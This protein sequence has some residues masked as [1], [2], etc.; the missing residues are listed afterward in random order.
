MSQKVFI[1]Y[2]FK[3]RELA[4]SVKNF[5]APLGGPC[6]GSPVYVENDV[7]ADG[8]NAI[9]REIASVMGSCKAALFIIGD[10]DHNSPWIERESRIA[11]SQALAM[12]AVQH[13]GTTGAPPPSLREAK[14]PFVEWNP[15]SL[16]EAL[17]R[18]AREVDTKRMR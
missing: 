12:V 16:C 13:P 15:E 2:N 8:E 18:A 11:I 7:S 17:N 6:E 10:E 1:S 9:D 5:F 4:G 14:V 3:N